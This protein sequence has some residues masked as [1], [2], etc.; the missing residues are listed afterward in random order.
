[1]RNAINAGLSQTK[2]EGFIA[3]YLPTLDPTHDIAD[4]WYEQ[5]L[6]VQSLPQDAEREILTTT[7]D[8]GDEVITEL[9]TPYE[10]ALAG[11]GDLETANPWLA[12]LRGE[13]APDRPVFTLTAEDW[14]AS[15]SMYQ[16]YLKKVGVEI[17]GKSV[18]LNESNQNGLAAVS[19][20]ID[21]GIKL[22]IDPFESPINLKLESL[23]GFSIIT[24]LT[25]EEFDSVY[26]TFN[27]ARQ[28]F[29]V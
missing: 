14:K 5:H 10:L 26:V 28:Q 27:L 6:L 24:V 13:T 17:N 18:S 12:G 15:S 11:R 19:T 3:L 22:G 20:S 25:Q 2:I 23:S 29:F 21:K 9:P 1:M 8:N 7:D 4:D 16:S